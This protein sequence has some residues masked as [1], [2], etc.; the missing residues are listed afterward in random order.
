MIAVVQSWNCH[1]LSLLSI[2]I[3]KLLAMPPAKMSLPLPPRCYLRHHLLQ[4]ETEED[5]DE[6]DM[7]FLYD[8]LPKEIEVH[9]NN[10]VRISPFSNPN[11]IP[12]RWRE[13]YVV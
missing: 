8:N 7:I 2:E 6:D 1:P 10:R 4:I 3:A 11:G 12:H 5:L 13:L 9:T